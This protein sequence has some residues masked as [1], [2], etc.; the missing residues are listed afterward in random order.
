[1][2]EWLERAKKDF[3]GIHEK[4]M[5]VGWTPELEQE[6][7][8]LWGDLPADESREMQSWIEGMGQKAEADARGFLA[9]RLFGQDK[10]TTDA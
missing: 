9:H 4:S 1:M 10:G 6:C 7:K 8:D 2:T 5:R 3:E